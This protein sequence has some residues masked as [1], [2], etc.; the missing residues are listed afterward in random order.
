MVT[1]ASQWK[2]VVVQEGETD[3][4]QT[5]KKQTNKTKTGKEKGV[6]LKDSKLVSHFVALFVLQEGLKH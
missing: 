6:C 5:D 4:K 2:S 3:K 1:G